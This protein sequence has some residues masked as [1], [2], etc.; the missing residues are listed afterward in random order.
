[1]KQ[2]VLQN[3]RNHPATVIDC[4]AVNWFLGTSGSGKSAIPMAIELALTGR[5]EGTNDRGTGQDHQVYDHG[6]GESLVRIVGGDGKKCWEHNLTTH[7]HL[8]EP[9]P[10]D[11]RTIRACLRARYL[12]QMDDS[13]QKNLLAAVLV[14][15]LTPEQL[16][17]ALNKWTPEVPSL[18]DWFQAE[19]HL[20]KA[21]N[22]RSTKE[23]DALWNYAY[24]M[25]TG[26]NKTVKD[27]EARLKVAQSA[28][29]AGGP[30]DYAPSV[31][32]TLREG[33]RT[34][35][36]QVAKLEEGGRAA[37]QI[38]EG[39][40]REWQAKKE[41][42]AELEKAVQAAD[43]KM[44]LHDPKQFPVIGDA[45]ACE[46]ALFELEQEAGLTEAMVQST[47][48]LIAQLTEDDKPCPE[49]KCLRAEIK[50]YNKEL[51][52]H[53]AALK[54]LRQKVAD[55]RKQFDAVKSAQAELDRHTEEYQRTEKE[56]TDAKMALNSPKAKLPKEPKLAEVADVAPL[57][58]QLADVREDI[59]RQERLADL[60][61]AWDRSVKDAEQLVVVLDAARSEATRWEALASE[62]CGAFATN[63]LRRRQLEACIAA[64]LAEVN[65]H[66]EV[67]EMQ[68]R[69]SIE[70]WC[71]EA[72]L[73]A[74][75]GFKPAS[76]LSKS[77]QACFCSGFAVAL[78]A[79]S[80]FP[81][82]VV[83]GHEADNVRRG[84][85][86]A[87]LTG[88]DGVQSFVFTTVDHGREL[89]QPPGGDVSM[90]LVAHGA[91]REHAPAPV[92]EVAA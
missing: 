63:G 29:N 6:T 30:A 68:A 19:G 86:W 52:E 51:Q 49:G 76:N 28:A 70:P 45:K 11:E 44:K 71:I 64:F 41:R 85:M 88:L 23:R 74:W 77:E 7:K 72:K 35:M 61:R 5:N 80:G 31:I 8:G 20:S 15:D 4:N 59:A 18:G 21:E 82:V 1:M 3:F 75:K 10:V 46:T 2:L 66:L 34:L 36:Q 26:A 50:R 79:N 90:F 54:E 67:Y 87:L 62:K 89:P 92:E 65:T 14:D 48:E 39:E 13:D 73:P 55:A 9:A 60:W 16:I 47:T 56:W 91:V 37:Q 25:R 69:I 32:D 40:R 22:Y 81:L 27:V 83:D 42:R 17:A 53:N 38:Y 24:D 33:E 43:A 58:K 78:G 84:Q 12:L 57:R